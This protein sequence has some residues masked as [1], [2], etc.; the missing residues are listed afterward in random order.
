[1]SRSL[2][3][4]CAALAIFCAS[5]ESPGQ[6][7]TA[8][9]VGTVTDSSGAVLQNATITIENI[10]TRDTRM[11]TTNESGSYV[12]TFL[13]IGKYTL[14]VA[15]AGFKEF[16]VPTLTLG[17]GDRTRVDPQMAVG[18]RAEKVEVQAQATILQTDSS[19]VGSLITTKAVQDLPLNGR[20]FMTLVQLIPGGSEGAQNDIRSGTRPDDRR[21]SSS[22]AVGG[23]SRANFLIDGMDNNDRTIFTIIVRPAVDAI[24]EL[25]VATNTFTAEVGLTNG[26]IVNL[27]T[28]SGTNSLHGTLFEYFRNDKLDA[29]SFFYQR[30]TD[31]KFRLNQY[32]GSIG[33]PIRKNKTF[34]F[35][36][37]ERYNQREARPYVATVPT[38]AM[39]GGNFSGVANIFDPASTIV[40]PA[41]R[42]QFIRTP[43]ANN[44]IPASRFDPVAINFLNLYPTPNRSGLGNNFGSAFIRSQDS[45]TFDV[46]VDHHFN[47]KDYLFGRVSYNNTF[48]V[49]PQVLPAVNGIF[50]TGNSGVYPGPAHQD[51]LSAQVNYLHTFSPTFLMELKGGY[52]RFALRSVPFNQG[53]N[54]NGK[55]GLANSISDPVNSGMALVQPAGYESIGD[56]AAIPLIQ[57]DNVY[58]EHASFTDTL[59]HHTLKFG[60]DLIRRQWT[61]F[62]STY[63]RGQFSFD[64]NATN[65][66]SGAT[67]SS[68]NSI[69]SMVLG[70]PGS[71]QVLLLPVLPGYRAWEIGEYIQD[72]WHAL[73]WLTLNIGVRYDIFTPAKEVA[74][75]ISN[76]SFDTR[77]LVVAG[78]NTSD[79][80]GVKTDRGDIAPR[81]GFAATLPWKMVLRGGFGLSYF[82]N[83]GGNGSQMKNAPFTGGAAVT[84][85]TTQPTYQMSQGL[86]PTTPQNPANPSGLLYALAANF[87][88]TYAEQISFF[89]QKEFAGNLLSIGYS[90]NLTRRNRIIPNI[91]Q[92][93]PGPGSIPQRRPF[94]ST[95]PN[96]TTI[97][98]TT[99]DGTQNYHSLQLILERRLRKGLT[100]SANYV[101]S[102]VLAEGL[103][104]TVGVQT[105]TNYR[106]DYGS[107]QLD[108]RH[109]WVVQANYELPFGTSLKGF[110]GTLIRGWQLNVV[111]LWQTGMPFTVTNNTARGNTGGSD[112]PN[113]VCDGTLSNPTIQKWFDTSCFVA[114]PL[115]SIGTAGVDI[116]TGPPER[117]INLSLL[118]N[119]RLAESKTLQFRAESFNI[120]NTPNFTL[121]NAALGASNFGTVSALSVFANPRQTQL[122]LKFLF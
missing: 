115:Y 9:V 86:P 30:G 42:S 4:V 15:A 119:F 76:L 31:T 21:Q 61:V 99:S 100:L 38:A 101:W 66:P 81:F 65:D 95:M 16:V 56:A 23:A 75:R 57:F 44:I 24:Q 18:E 5:K 29:R 3:A 13:P 33:G 71:M 55:L 88:S 72:D 20:N 32:G 51:A 90:G 35:G 122:A 41:N 22:V 28:K 118:K 48:T 103:G 77:G 83:N 110:E 36:D 97:M 85:S 67:P 87:R 8:D 112:R 116:L 6:V 1:M 34:F 59:G 64:S 114:Q 117:Y 74:N 106:L 107:A 92:P 79:T 84:N 26:A 53:T 69:A 52:G 91:N 73:P 54:V 46:K 78:V 40:N 19:Q 89:L 80:A 93:E 58:Q 60:A 109:R 98:Y 105:L 50:P 63:P 11:A 104:T 39:I 47:E 25:N 17:S 49:T 14:R 62:Q 102:H 7:T 94:Y 108:V 10:D 96:V 120:T 121:P 113:R 43:F 111:G 12:F 68:G 27:L 45:S 37:F 70:F 2:L 82:P